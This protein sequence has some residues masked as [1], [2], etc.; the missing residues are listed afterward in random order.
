[1]KIVFLFN[2]LCE[3]CVINAQRDFSNHWPSSRAIYTDL[4]KSIK[5][6]V[7]NKHTIIGYI[8]IYISTE[9]EEKFIGLGEYCLNLLLN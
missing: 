8:Y 6:H 9:Q 1:M 5:V 2:I 3:K 7:Q 4:L